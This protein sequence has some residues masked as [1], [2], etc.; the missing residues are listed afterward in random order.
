MVGGFVV[1]FLYVYLRIKRK[2]YIQFIWLWLR[3]LILGER[4][5]RVAILGLT[6]D[7]IGA[8]KN[9]YYYETDMSPSFGTIFSFDFIQPFP[10]QAFMHIILP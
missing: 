3:D 2:N 6:R 4:S 5:L 9:Y 1:R 8:V 10:N 7:F